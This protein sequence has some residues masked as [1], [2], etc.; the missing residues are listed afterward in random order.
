MKKKIYK[1]TYILLMLYFHEFIKRKKEKTIN[2]QIV[3][4]I[5]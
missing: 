5:D 2:P 3:K 1:L 4:I